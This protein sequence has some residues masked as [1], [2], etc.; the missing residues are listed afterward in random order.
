MH[1]HPADARHCSDQERDAFNRISAGE[2]ASNFDKQI[3]DSLIEKGLLSEH[4]GNI[5]PPAIVWSQWEQ[6]NKEHSNAA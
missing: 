3:I 2:D 1:E 4:E 6:Y 5:Y